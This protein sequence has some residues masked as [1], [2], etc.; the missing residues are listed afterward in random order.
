MDATRLILVRHGQAHCNVRGVIGGP[1]GCTG[2]TDHGRHQ[3]RLLAARL[4]AEHAQAPITA[5]Y[6]TPL[7]RAC[8]TAD[9]IS[10]EL[11]I[12]ITPDDDLREP[13]YGNA[14]GQPWAH[15]VAAFGR[16]P[17]LYPDQPI[18]PGAEPWTS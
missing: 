12:P 15:V 18:A 16:I 1:R 14:D 13:D 3:A 6:T 2:L 8:Q 11:S 9:I 17:A 4:H 10:G 5:A 7:P